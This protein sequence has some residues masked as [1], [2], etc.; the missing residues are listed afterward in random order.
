MKMS[1]GKVLNKILKEIVFPRLGTSD[2]LVLLGPNIGEDAAIIKV[3]NELVAFK[4]DPIT[5]SL[6]EVGFLAVHV[7]ANDIA[8]R[9]ADPKWFLQCI[10]LPEDATVE[11]LDKI[12]RQMDFA[13]KEIGVSIVGGHTEVTLGIDHPIVVGS[14]LGIVKNSR[15]FTSGGARAG[16]ILYMT[17]YAGLEGTAIL[18]SETKIL[19]KKGEGFVRSCKSLLNLISVVKECRILRDLECITSMHDLT[20][21]GVLGGVWELAEAASLGVY[22][23][24]RRVPVLQMTRIICGELNLDPYRL[25]SSGSLLFTVARGSEHLVESTLKNSGIPFAMIGEMLP[26]SAGRSYT[27]IEGLRLPLE[28]P[29]ADELWRGLE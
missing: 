10:L 4:S 16:D 19:S 6:E 17:K 11:D 5:G 25:I 21:G 27:N 1:V 3:G 29:S 20:E 15:F 7:N 23:D 2:P 14:M 13:A 9:G 26:S 28:P 24:L 8:T 22:L 12:S 18:S